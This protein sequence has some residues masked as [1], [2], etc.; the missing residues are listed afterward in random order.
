M[1]DTSEKEP[2]R[3]SQSHPDAANLLLKLSEWRR[4]SDMRKARRWLDTLYRPLPCDEWDKKHPYGS[5][6]DRYFRMVTGHWQTMAVFWKEGYLPASLIFQT[7]RE[8]R[9]TWEKCADFIDDR[10]AQGYGA[11]YLKEWEELCDAFDAW[12]D[13]QE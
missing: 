11:T 1:S 13:E 8:F 10:R 7:T 3:I 12:L 2:P 5:E 4:D 9:R 6:P